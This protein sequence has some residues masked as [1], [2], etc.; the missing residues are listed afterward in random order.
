M[1]RKYLVAV[2][3]V[4][5]LVVALVVVIPMIT[6][7]QGLFGRDQQAAGTTVQAPPS[8]AGSHHAC[9]PSLGDGHVG[10]REPDG[11]GSGCR[12][13]QLIKTAEDAYKAKPKDLTAVLSL[14]DAYFQAQRLDDSTRLFNEALALGG[15]ERG[16]AGRPCHDRVLEGQP[17]AG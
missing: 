8:G 11:D 16:R 14:A 9:Q 3:I 1:N 12:V 2:G 4:A 7:R 6:A 15:Q 10:R 17:A 13:E 5:I